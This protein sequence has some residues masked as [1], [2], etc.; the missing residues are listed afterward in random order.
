VLAI[1]IW[2]L[3]IVSIFGIVYA[4]L[5]GLFFLGAKALFIYHV[6]ANG[7][8]VGPEQFPEMHARVTEI[9]RKIGLDPVPDTYIMQ[10]GGAL[11]ALATKFLDSNMMVLYSD[12]LSAC[13]GNAAARDMIIGHELGHIRAGHLEW[14]WLI[15]PALIVPF[16]AS[17][18]SRA[19]E[20]TSDRYGMVGAGQRDG[21]ELG[22]I[23]LAAGGQLAPQVN[24]K[25]FVR[26]RS[27]LGGFWM[28]LAH[29][30]ATHPPLTKRVAALADFRV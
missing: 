1:P 28:G 16:L 12:L 13:E 27:E 24:R 18:L 19:R 8:R 3:L 10:A 22:L 7:V 4:L 14:R 15:A 2:I 29:L 17:A 23:V 25:S 30:I 9:A 11:N 21:A 6:R 20:Y 26:Q 5:L